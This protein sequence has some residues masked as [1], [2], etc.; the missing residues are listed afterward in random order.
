MISL[1]LQVIALL[2]IDF[3]LLNPDLSYKPLLPFYESKL[4]SVYATPHKDLK[5][6]EF[7]MKASERIPLYAIYRDSNISAINYNDT[8]R[9]LK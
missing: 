2:P 3:F 1:K 9:I 8:S 6:P 7:N 5:G 4:E